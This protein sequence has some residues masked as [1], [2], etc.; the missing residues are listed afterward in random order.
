M[1]EKKTHLAGF[2]FKI[3][4]EKKKKLKRKKKKVKKNR[5]ASG[6]GTRGGAA[7]VS[8]QIFATGPGA[9]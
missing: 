1:A 9:D 7:T 4:D 2:S 8:Q 6:D 3:E 5:E